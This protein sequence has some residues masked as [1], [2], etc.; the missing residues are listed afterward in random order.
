M[1]AEMSGINGLPRNSFGFLGISLLWSLYNDF[2]PVLLQ[3]GRPDF[4]K[5][6]ESRALRLAWRQPGW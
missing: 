4:S 6:P 5:G 3:A 2:M 1:N